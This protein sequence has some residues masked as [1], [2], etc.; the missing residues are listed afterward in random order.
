MRHS[1]NVLPLFLILCVS[2]IIEKA[3]SR[4]TEEEGIDEEGLAWAKNKIKAIV[5]VLCVYGNLK[6]AVETIALFLLLLL[7]LVWIEES[8]IDLKSWGEQ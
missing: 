8:L 6:I 1:C 5:A 4:G 3:K 2:S 7:C